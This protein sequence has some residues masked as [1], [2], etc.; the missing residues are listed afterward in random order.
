M[1]GTWV[2][3]T[4]PPEGASLA[5][6]IR[7]Q[8]G[9]PKLD[10]LTILVRESAQ[11]SWDARLPGSENPVDYTIN[12]WTAGPAHAPTWRKL[13][14]RNA[15][16]N[17]HLPLRESLA[18]PSLRLLA[19]SDRGTSGLGG[20]TRAD[21][22]T[23]RDHDFVSFVRNVGEPR[24]TELGGG[25]YGFGKAIF[26]LVSNAGTILIHTRCKTN[27]GYETRL[28]GSS[29]WQS[30]VANT[31]NGPVRYTGRH[32]WGDDTGD[33]VEPLLGAEADAVAAQLGLT[34]FGE[35]ET[36]TTIVVVDPILDGREPDD[37][38]DFM[39]ET[40]A[41]HLWPKMLGSSEDAAP[42]RFSVTCE[43]TH[44]R[45]PDP[46]KTWPLSLFVAAYEALD[47]EA[48]A[49]LECFRPKKVLGKLGLVKRTAPPAEPTEVTRLVGVEQAVHHVCLMRQ[50]ELVVT[51]RPGPKPPSEFQHYAGV[52]RAASELDQAFSDAEPPTHDDWNPQSLDYPYSTYVNTAFRRIDDATLDLL[53]LAGRVRGDSAK[54]ALGAA[55]A[56]FASLVSGTTGTGGA[57]DYSGYA[58]PR[59][60]AQ[61]KSRTSCVAPESDRAGAPEVR[62][63]NGGAAGNGHESI[64]LEQFDAL[65]KTTD[66]PGRDVSSARPRVEYVGDPYYEEHSGAT[67]LVQEF[68]LPVPGPQRVH[69][70]PAVALS[71]GGR[72]TDPPAGADTPSV[73]GWQDEDGQLHGTS[74]IVTQ[75][76]P[77]KIWRLFVRPARD[78]MTDLIIR[79]EAVHQP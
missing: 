52:F 18:K 79:T 61:P 60:N 11:N 73:M 21:D 58:F 62:A 75:G 24:D 71:T 54:V 72:E 5:E 36:G 19:V 42:M 44:H 43:G 46:R 28:I 64:D 17:E 26:Y 30:Y 25:T 9:R 12:L 37:A 23:I 77:N 35:T 45:V 68:R 34:P 29:L 32:W 78:T 41:W 31:P 6:G 4:F 8:L 66:V 49:T 14:T 69:A 3:Q 39:A 59:T 13:L 74:S 53:D 63:T 2:S 38:A 55:S 7:N 47:G 40:I 48:G 27:G 70:D 15:P 57:T 56:M 50:P 51:Y 76:N 22:V 10:L 1:T 33:V 65:P 16:L 67:V 20:P